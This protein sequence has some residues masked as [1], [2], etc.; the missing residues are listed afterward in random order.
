[1]RIDITKKIKHVLINQK[2]KFIRNGMKFLILTSFIFFSVCQADKTKS[3]EVIYQLIERTLPG[4]SQGFILRSMNTDKYEGA[5]RI[6]SKKNKI[7]I[8]G[9]DKIA[10]CKGF[11]HYLRY[12]LHGNISNCGSQIPP[13]EIL[14]AVNKPIFMGTQTTLRWGL[15]Y[16]TYNYSFSFW[17]WDDWEKE[18]DWLAMQGINLPLAILGTEAVWRNTLEQF[19]FTD[20][21]IESFIPGP[22]YLCWWLLDNLEGWGGPASPEWIKN[23]VILQRK[24]LARMRELGMEPV[25]PAFYGMVPNSAIEK[26]PDS[27]IYKDTK[28]NGFQRP[29]FIDPNDSLFSKM[30]SVFYTE[31][32]KLFGKALY[33]SGDPFHEGGAHTRNVTL[34]AHN[35]QAAMLKHNPKSTWVLQGWQRNPT[36]S[37]LIGTDPDKTLLLDLYGEER[38]MYE[39]RKAF[40]GRDFLWCNINDFG[41]NTYM[42]ANIDSISIVPVKLLNHKYTEFYKGIGICAEG[43]FTDPMV[44]DLFYDMAWQDHSFNLSAWLRDYS[45][46]RYGKGNEKTSM[47]VS[48]LANSVYNASRRTESILCARPSLY[49]ERTTTWGPSA[50]PAYNQDSLFASFDAL[51]E[52]DD[53]YIVNTETFRFDLSNVCRQLLTGIAYDKL[54]KI[55]ESYNIRNRES[56]AKNSK[57]FLDLIL[58]ADSITAFMPR[59]SFYEWQKNAQKQATNKEDSTLFLWNANRLITLWGDKEASVKLHD[60]A[61]REWYGLLSSFYFPR[62]EMYFNYLNKTL[63]GNQVKEPDFYEFENEWCKKCFNDLSDISKSNF[64]NVVK[65]IYKYAECVPLSG[66]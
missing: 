6:S 42:Y 59:F 7:L 9:T 65:N 63:E 24:I 57:E 28:W 12:Y 55:R 14:P 11:Y 32:E 36:D 37:L 54:Q 49:A 45:T 33:Y 10:I 15:Y 41:N 29:A 5:F 64:K 16:C 38:P 34:A 2:K 13:F 66:E 46:Y 35:I 23:R 39:R 61:Y 52:V 4:Y 31:Q 58:F 50:K 51:L 47:A 20:K 1:M 30:A 17:D 60:Y 8:E 44:Y 40:G 21:E 19:N 18:I 56:F 27:K 3:F 43:A 26:F 25:L 62:W 53:E 22:A 48:I